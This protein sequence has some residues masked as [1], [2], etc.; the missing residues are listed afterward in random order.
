MNVVSRIQTNKIKKNKET[1]QI[2]KKIKWYVA[3]EIKSLTAPKSWTKEYN[4]CMHEKH[5]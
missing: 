4:L 2:K 5:E 1:Q 3:N